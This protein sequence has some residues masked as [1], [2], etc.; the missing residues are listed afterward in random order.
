LGAHK[1]QDRRIV[2]RHGDDPAPLIVDGDGSVL[3]AAWANIWLLDGDELI[4]PPL[5]GRILPGVTRARLLELA[6]PLGLRVR[7]AP[8]RLDEARA[9][10]AMFLTSSLRLAVPASF[11]RSP[12]ENLAVDRIRASLGST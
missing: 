9:A 7:E 4:T 10:Q 8:I 2:E 5:D 6:P 12:Q 11:D 3:E 1:W